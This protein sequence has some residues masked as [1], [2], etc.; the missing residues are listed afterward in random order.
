[1]RIALVHS[2]YGS[3]TPSGENRVVESEVQAL[4]QAGHSVR[5]Y[6]ARTEDFGRSTLDPLAAAL[7]VA[8]GIGRTPM[9]NLARDRMDLVHVHN[10][11]PNW[12]SRWIG[13]LDIP[14]VAT[15][16]NFRPL[17]A[18]GMLFRDGH[19]C[20]LCPAGRR[21]AGVRYRCYRE[22]RAASL[23]LAIANRDGPLGHTLLRSAR[24]LIVLNETAREIYAWAGLPESKLTVW[25]NFLPAELDPGW[26]VSSQQEEKWIYVGRLSR[27][28]GIVELARKWPAH[29]PL[30]VI[31]DGEHRGAVESAA[32]GKAIEVVGMQKRAATI[33]AM[34]GCTGLVFP[35]LCL[36]SFPL[37]YAE[38][39]AVGLPVLAWES[40]VV[41]SFVRNHG[42]GSTVT[43]QDDLNVTLNH[44]VE[45]FPTL[46]AACRTL[47][48][49]QLSED[50]YLRRAE[51]LYE[52]VL[53]ESRPLP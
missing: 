18:N 45:R 51:A 44:E 9:K 27:E 25:P 26:T 49:T 4:E 20:T 21:F 46:R 36:E 23:P 14:V 34:R 37:V 40:N 7:R 3:K 33:E 47:F 50:S 22:S 42:T 41:A 11:F 12:A 53:E 39:M 5:L 19:T 15:L 28:K 1:M 6:A 31:G 38:A 52:S 13:S 48:T 30:L 17:C 29:R 24:R 16:H 35:S 32:R 10:L 2:F 8:T 43:W